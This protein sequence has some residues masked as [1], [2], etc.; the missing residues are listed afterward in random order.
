M[1]S[2]YLHSEGT[3]SSPQEAVC[4]LFEPV[5]YADGRCYRVGTLS[6]AALLRSPPI[7]F[8]P[9]IHSELERATENVP[10]NRK[11]SFA[12]IASEM[13]GEIVAAVR[14]TQLDT[15]HGR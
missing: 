14:K 8:P 3:Q 1:K 12:R 15:A 7:P 6:R 13:P 4:H 5:W 2:T 11:Q 10:K 9:I